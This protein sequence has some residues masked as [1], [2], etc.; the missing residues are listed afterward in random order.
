MLN[1]RRLFED[2]TGPS[3]PL[4]QDQDRGLGVRSGCSLRVYGRLCAQVAGQC[5]R[6][7]TPPDAHRLQPKLQPAAAALFDGYWCSNVSVYGENLI[8]MR[9]VHNLPASLLRIQTTTRTITTRIISHKNT[10]G[11]VL[12]GG[13]YPA[14][15]HSRGGETPT[16]NLTSKWAPPAVRIT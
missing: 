3:D 2:G 5:R 15:T 14:A 10:E 9:G 7:K 6:L 1:R 4:R 13:S 8:A 16:L 12:W 11:L